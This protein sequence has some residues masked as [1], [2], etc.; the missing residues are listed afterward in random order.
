MQSQISPPQ[1]HYEITC[2]HDYKRDKGEEAD[3]D[4]DQGGVC[5]KDK[6]W[7]DGG[8]HTGGKKRIFEERDGGVCPGCVGE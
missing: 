2:C 7:R 8:E 6:G 4:E 1:V 5:C 3:Q